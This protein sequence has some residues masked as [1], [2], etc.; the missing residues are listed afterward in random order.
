MT[1]LAPDRA[2]TRMEAEPP[3]RGGNSIVPAAVMLVVALAV[4][5]GPA[6]HDELDNP[7]L[8]TATTVFVSLVVQ[9]LP[10]LVLGVLVS[11]IIAVL[12]PATFFAKAL[13]KNGA[14]AVPIA[15]VAGLA[16]PGCECGSVPIASGLLRRGV[17]PAAAL[18]FL[19][20]APALNPV[21][22]VATAAAFPGTPEMVWAR[23]IASALAAM[24]MGWL[25]LA[26]GRSEWIKLPKR[27]DLSGMPKLSAIALTIRHDFVHAGGFL[28]VGGA[29]AA[30]LKVFVPPEWL[31]SV[32][33]DPVAG[34]LAMAVLAVVL[35]L[36]SEADAFVAASLNQFPPVALLT[37]LVVGPMI[38]L[39]LFVMQA[40]T[41]GR[42][43]ALRFAP[44]TFAVA[45]AASAVVGWLLL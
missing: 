17:A 24:T 12:V 2:E 39:K 43:F 41:F 8:T 18:T 29:A 26:L 13:P 32:A 30:L 31:K 9:A 15:G 35:S 6:F 34:V 14:V 28:V 40:G 21:V 22:L 33:D 20:A 1:T 42:T 16:L 19:L 23:A 5:V 25:W 7:K 3:R 44:T 4:V 37:F 11:A 10:F 36:C 45:I 27:P 38:D